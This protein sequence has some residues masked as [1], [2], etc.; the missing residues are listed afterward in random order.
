MVECRFALSFFLEVSIT[1]VS[2]LPPINKSDELR[3]H[4]TILALE[5]DIEAVMLDG[6]NFPGGA[7]SS[8]LSSWR[9]RGV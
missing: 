7:V 2:L 8:V 9:A 5:S 6:F 4:G 1:R 3:A